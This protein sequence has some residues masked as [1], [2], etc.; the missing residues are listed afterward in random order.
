MTRRTGRVLLFGL[1]AAAMVLL[2]AGWL[3]WPRTAITRENVAKI[4]QGMTRAEVEAILGGPPRNESSAPL[5][6][7]EPDEGLPDL[8][9]QA[10]LRQWMDCMLE[11]VVDLERQRAMWRSNQVEVYIG[12][13]ATGTVESCESFP[14]RRA[15]EGPLE[16]LRRWLGL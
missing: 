9:R 4:Q 8:I 11:N 7:D 5:D 13:S 16:R 1:P 6:L 15:T 2:A 3:L 14:M 10:R 12:W